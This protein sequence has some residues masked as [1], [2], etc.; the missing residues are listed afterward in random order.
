MKKRMA[1]GRSRGFRM[2]GVAALFAA[3]AP[4][5]DTPT[6]R[7]IVIYSG[8]RLSAAP[9][10]MEE[11]DVWVREAMTDIQE[12]PAFLISTLPVPRE[13]YPWD[14]LE[15]EGD[16]ARVAYNNRAPDTRTPYMI[17]AYLHLMREMGQLDQWLPGTQA[18]EGYE[19]E[20]AILAQVSE[21]WLYGRT[22]FDAHAYQPLE[23]LIYATESGYLDAFILTARPEKFETERDRWLGNI[24]DGEYQYTAWFEETF[25][26]LP[27]GLRAEEFEVMPDG[28]ARPDSVAADTT[29]GLR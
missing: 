11:A 7:P 18:L 16:T 9:E 24:P 28:E 14:G 8:A 4:A 10:R 29:G 12:N 23:E 15:I 25:Q 17:Y 2:L 26:E 21:V 27:P 3:C 20:R 13:I 5:A 22:V 1:P 19:L 6:P